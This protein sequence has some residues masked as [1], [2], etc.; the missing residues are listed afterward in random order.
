MTLVVISSLSASAHSDDHGMLLAQVQ[1]AIGPSA[2]VG[3]QPP[4][5][6]KTLAAA[7][8]RLRDAEAVSTLTAEGR[9]LYLADSG[10]GTYTTNSMGAAADRL[11]E[12]GEFRQAIRSAAVTLYLGVNSRNDTQTAFAKVILASAYLASGDLRNAQTFASGALTHRVASNYYYLLKGRANKILADVAMR[13]ENYAKA[14]D[15]YGEALDAAQADL[16]FYVRASLALAHSKLK[17]FD[18]AR[19]SVKDAEG[20]V[21]IVPPQ[22]QAAARGSLLRIR[23]SVALQEGKADEAARL[24]EDALKTQGIDANTAY[25]KFW[26]LEGLARARL[27]RGDAAG[28]LGTYM[29]AVDVSEQVRGLFRS[30]E[31]KSALFGEMQDVFSEAVRL[32]VESG[33]ID[34]AW[35]INEKGRSR[36]L[37]DMIRNRVALAE[38]SAVFAEASNKTFKIGDLV[39]RIK[40]GEVVLSYRVL[41]GRTYAWATRTTG[42]TVAT[43]DMTRKNLG[44]RVEAF[45]DAVI[46]DKPD[47][48]SLGA[49]LHD[50]LVKPANVAA[51]ESLTIIPHDVLHYLPYQALWTGDAYLLQKA[52]ISYAPS[53]NALVQLL[54]R[55]PSAT[56]RFFALGNPDLGDPSRALPGAQKEV[57]ALM[58]LFPDSETYFGSNATRQRFFEGAAKSRLVHVASHGSV[59]PIDPLYSKLYLAKEANHEGTVDA[60]EIYGLKLGGTELVV[61]SACETGLGNVSR[62]DE[63]WGFTRSFLSAGAPALLV[64]LWEVSDE[65]TE[66][67]MKRFYGDLTKGIGRREALRNASL[68]VLSDARFSSPVYWSAFNLVGDMR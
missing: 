23:G 4:G 3:T 22:F 27:A 28:A 10:G 20:F 59:D 57:E 35:E 44:R 29:E 8:S 47:A 34:T 55:K 11:I 51:G 67:L 16:R 62:G 30:E 48:K 19:E 14:V 53:A 39:S 33:K 31:V 24:Y 26:I 21:G 54:D 6:I 9:A 15:L 46:E 65:A 2:A 60:R 17:R 18:K 50:L 40:P 56:G 32:L 45:R 38:G 63:V 12:Q 36:A 64:S 7:Q 49:E 66:M 68:A 25:D 52:Q 37:L 1:S 58:T 43:I 41:D 13:E 61:L 42:T 5:G